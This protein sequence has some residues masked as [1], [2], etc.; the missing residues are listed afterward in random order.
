MDIV[1][2]GF[3]NP[4]AI[5]SLVLKRIEE[6]RAADEQGK[7]DPIGGDAQPH[8]KLHMKYFLK[9]VALALVAVTTFWAYT[10]FRTLTVTARFDPELF[11]EDLGIVALFN[12]PIIFLTVAAY[13]K[14]WLGR[15]PKVWPQA[16]AMLLVM[17]GTSVCCE[18]YIVHDEQTFLKQAND[19]K[20]D[21]FSR[22]RSWPNG[23]SRLIYS[24]KGGLLST[25]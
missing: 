21:P 15:P 17:I 20:Q 14:G 3:G 18:L 10:G 7:I 11:I 5:D 4:V 2:R 13:A 24:A 6:W 22:S 19:S 23:E 9:I 25:D 8:Y 1:Q 16:G 12:L